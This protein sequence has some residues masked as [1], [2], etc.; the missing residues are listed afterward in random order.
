MNEKKVLYKNSDN[1]MIS[2]VCSGLAEYA[3]MDVSLVRVLFALI[4]LST[5]FPIILYIVFVFVL[6]DKKDIISNQEKEEL[7]ED[8][9]KL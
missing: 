4:A 5:A 8:E 6:P 9:Y 3:N 7:Y 1:S 2:G